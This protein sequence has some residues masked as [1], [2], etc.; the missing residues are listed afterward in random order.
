MVGG[1]AYPGGSPANVA[2]ALGRQGV[3]VTFATQLGDDAHGALVRAHLEQSG[4]DL[5]VAPAPR[6]S[7]ATAVLDASGAASYDF[8]IS[9]DPVFPE[10]PSSETV[11]VGSFSAMG[12]D[13]PPGLLSYDINVRPALMP[14]DARTRIERLVD[15]AT[16]VKASDEDLAWLYPAL[17]WE[18]AGETLLDRGPEVVW[19]TRGAAGATAFSREGRVDVEAPR[20]VVVDTIGAGDTFSAGL[21]AGFLEWGPQWQR[22]GEH[23][24]AL[25]AVTA[26]RAGADPPYADITGVPSEG[27]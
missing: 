3:P 2:V 9:W 27:G 19:V 11:H 10:L 18:A 12:V 1:V 14:D 8:Q 7:T 22:V 26:S 5:V 25:A 4:V 21:I 15:R 20:V 13:P 16:I 17:T 24:A 23:A 6:T